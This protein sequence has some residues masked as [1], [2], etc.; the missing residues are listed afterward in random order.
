MKEK[1]TLRDWKFVPQIQR[2]LK[3]WTEQRN[4]LCYVCLLVCLE[5]TTI[6]AVVQSGFVL[7]ISVGGSASA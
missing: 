5:M 6:V 1:R 4:L 2:K 3:S 7:I